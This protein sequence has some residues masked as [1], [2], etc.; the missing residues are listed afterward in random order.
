[1]F[2][3]W[4]N[5]AMKYRGTEEIPGREHNPIIL[6][7][8]K[9]IKLGGIKD[10]E[11]AWCA[12]FVGGTLEECGILSSRSAGARSYQKWGQTLIGPAVGA[13]VTF[14]RDSPASYKG[15]VGFVIGRDQMD[16]LMVL[17]GNQGNTVNIKPFATARVL[18]YS[19]PESMELPQKIGMR[20]LPVARSD[21]RLSNNEA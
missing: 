13:I 17:G 14:W 6:D 11:T 1:M 18:A 21:G 15:H 16:N 3:P 19:W 2:P 9:K 12:A 5:I 4:L 8:W 20:M 7:W 10:D